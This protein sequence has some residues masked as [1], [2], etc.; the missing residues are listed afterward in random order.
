MLHGPD[1]RAR[2]E[3]LTYREDGGKKEY[4][5]IRRN[6]HQKLALVA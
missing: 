2:K 1:Q 5:V 4:V 6:K 3:G